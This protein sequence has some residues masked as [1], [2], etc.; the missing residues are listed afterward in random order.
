VGESEARVRQPVHILFYRVV[1]P[2]LVD[3][4]RVLHERMETSRHLLGAEPDE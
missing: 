1:R 3:I 2:G 4:V